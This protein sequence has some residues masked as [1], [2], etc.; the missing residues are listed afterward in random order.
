MPQKQRT[1]VIGLDG[2]P[3]SLLERFI[4]DGTMPNMERLAS[5]GHLSR[6]KVTLPE[7]S[8]VSWPS[9]MTGVN[10]GTHGIYGFVDLKPGDRLEEQ[11]FR[12]ASRHS[13]NEIPMR[14][15]GFARL[16]PGNFGT[17]NPERANSS[18]SPYH[19]DPL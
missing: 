1:L 15:S 19:L 8:A 14:S 2:V 16:S 12:I 11:I 18:T 10:P 5:L 6:M 17:V 3:H 4:A 7:I 13:S 9:F